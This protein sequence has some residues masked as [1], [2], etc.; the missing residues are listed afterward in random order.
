MGQRIPELDPVCSYQAWQ[1]ATKGRVVE[2][3]EPSYKGS[4]RASILGEDGLAGAAVVYEKES[5]RY[6]LQG[7]ERRSSNNTTTTTN[8]TTNT[9]TTMARRSI[10]GLG[11]SRTSSGGDQTPESHSD[12]EYRPSSRQDRRR[13][14]T[15]S[16]MQAAASSSSS[17]S[18]A[19]KINECFECGKVFRSRHQLNVHLRVHRRDGGKASGGGGDKDPRASRDDRWGSTT[20]DPESGSPSRPGTPGYGDSPPA[21]ALGTQASEMGTANPGAPTVP[22]EEKT[23]VY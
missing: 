5:S 21:S 6:V 20:S 3:M 19:S 14:S 12:S 18:S 8:T 22:P 9:N 11:G 4:S 13:P 7:Q 15:S 10:S 2:P 1:L 17:S 23:N 16:Q